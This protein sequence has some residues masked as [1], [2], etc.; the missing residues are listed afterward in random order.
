MYSVAPFAATSTLPMLVSATPNT[1]ATVGLAV[2][3]GVGVGELAAVPD[4]APPHADR[5]I[6]AAMAAVAMRCMLS[7]CACLERGT[8]GVPARMTGG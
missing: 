4:P 3:V 7:S 1:G 5:T 6:I 8:F 2:G